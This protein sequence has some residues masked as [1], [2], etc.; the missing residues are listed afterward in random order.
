MS[1]GRRRKK[2]GVRS[3]SFV[4]DEST[5]I[6]RILPLPL[7][8]HHTDSPRAASASQRSQQSPSPGCCSSHAAATPRRAAAARRR[9]PVGAAASAA[10]GIAA[11]AAA[12]CCSDQEEGS[13]LAAAERLPSSRRCGPRAARGKSRDPRRREREGGERAFS[14][15]E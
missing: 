6:L 15:E 9:R 11:A 10:R 12:G 2:K 8:L 5:A 7:S 4:C 1:D 3:S 14:L 13:T